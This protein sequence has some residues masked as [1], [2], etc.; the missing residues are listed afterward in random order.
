MNEEADV[1]PGYVQ[2]LHNSH[3]RILDFDQADDDVRWACA[4]DALVPTSGRP[5]TLMD[6]LGKAEYMSFESVTQCCRDVKELQLWK[7][8]VL[9]CGQSE[10]PTEQWWMDETM[11]WMGY[12]LL[13][14]VQDQIVDVYSAWIA[15]YSGTKFVHFS[16]S[17]LTWSP[18]LASLQLMGKQYERILR[19]RPSI[20]LHLPVFVFS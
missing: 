14:P 13:F 4:L 10:I 12:L 3:R 20:A 5:H 18:T 19:S 11:L 6:R 7:Y 8:Q 17:C 15:F 1:S 2:I 16:G 9:R